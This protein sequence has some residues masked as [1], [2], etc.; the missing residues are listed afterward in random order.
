LEIIR[1]GIYWVNLD[2]PGKGHE[3]QKRRPC[4]VISPEAMHQTQMAV[5]CPLTTTIRHWPFRIG[6]NCNGKPGEIMVDQ[7]R[8]V[9]LK[10]FNAFIEVLEANDIQKLKGIIARM[11]VV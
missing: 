4:V 11:Y 6:T 3:Q 5:I 7:I 8:A 9:S 10:R 1:Y 2:P